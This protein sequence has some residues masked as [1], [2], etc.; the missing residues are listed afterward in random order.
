MKNVTITLPE[1]VA[2]RARVAAA[3]AEMSL[4]RW[5]SGLVQLELG[6]WPEGA[7]TG[8]NLYRGHWQKV[9]KSP[10]RR[11]NSK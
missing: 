3:E 5:I 1:E 7:T 2:K 6:D 11:S 8:D 9:A 10:S 4:S